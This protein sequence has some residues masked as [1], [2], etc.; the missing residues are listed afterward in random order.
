MSE[1]NQELGAGAQARIKKL[2]EKNKALESRL[3]ET[4][5]YSEKIQQLEQQLAQ[6]T[7][8]LEEA[9]TTSAGEIANL[10]RTY[11]IERALLAKGIQ[12]EEGINIAKMVYESI[13]EDSRPEIAEWLSGELPRAVSAY[14]PQAP[15][16]QAQ[17]PAANTDEQAAVDNSLTL[18]QPQNNGIIPKPTYDGRADLKAATRST[19]SW[20][21][22]R[23]L[24]ID[25][26]TGKMKQV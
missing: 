6:I 23:H 21:E 11:T 16:P 12:S 14:F 8:L 4:E 7:G 13:P 26:H 1:D 3:S 5:Q 25:E 15:A 10:T 2:L 24:F 22:N 9:K 19:E 18:R 20:R 17:P